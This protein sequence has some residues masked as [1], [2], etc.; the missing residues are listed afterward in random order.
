MDLFF[1]DKLIFG[2]IV[3]L[4]TNSFFQLEVVTVGLLVTQILYPDKKKKEQ[5]K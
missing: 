2:F 5:D 1:L 4:F 3:K